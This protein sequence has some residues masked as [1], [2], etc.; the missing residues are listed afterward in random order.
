MKTY[1]ELNHNP[2]NNDLKQLAVKTGLSKRVLQVNDTPPGNTDVS[3]GSALG[4]RGG[5]PGWRRG[6]VVSGVRH[7]RS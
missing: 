5:R 7:E 6:L 3:G 4:L 1:F 2:D